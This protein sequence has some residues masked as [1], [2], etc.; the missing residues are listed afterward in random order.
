MN[1]KAVVEGFRTLGV[2]NEYAVWL[3]ITLETGLAS[4]RLQTEVG[5]HGLEQVALAIRFVEA[6]DALGA[7]LED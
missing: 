6:K 4:Q 3:T 1:F 2:P 5:T 7:E